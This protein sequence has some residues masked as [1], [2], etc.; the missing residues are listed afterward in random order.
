MFLYDVI[1]KYITIMFYY[2]N[3][4]FIFYFC[5][6]FF[7]R[8][9]GRTRYWQSK[10]R[11]LSPFEV[12]VELP[13]DAHALAVHAIKQITSKDP[14]TDVKTYD[15]D[16]ED[17]DNDTWIVSGMSPKQ[18]ELLSKWPAVSTYSST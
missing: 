18:I 6:Y 16:E 3:L 13:K 10:F 12:P 7:S 14:T 17:L 8:K 9:Y 4:V 11:H 2:L 15:T 5:I 1:T